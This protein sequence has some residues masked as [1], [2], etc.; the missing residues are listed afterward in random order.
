VQKRKVAAPRQGTATLT[1][2]L[3]PDLRDSLKRL[4]AARKATA[5]RTGQP[6]FIIGIVDEAITELANLLKRGE[7]V[8]FIPVPRSSEGRTALRVGT[9][10]HAIAQKSS[11]AADV[12]LAD[13]V[14][15]ALSLYVRS[16]AREIDQKTK[17]AS[18]RGRK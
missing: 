8:A 11:E 6:K 15:T 2:G 9:D 3:S 5:K 14:R 4:S 7:K 16:H 13:F 18:H 10:A 12:K 1:L 17:A